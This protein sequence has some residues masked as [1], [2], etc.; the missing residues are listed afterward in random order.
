MR[1]AA[2]LRSVASVLFHRARMEGDMDDELRA[3]I[4]S[5]ADDLERS[6]LPRAEAQRR[7]RMEFGG[8]QKFKEECHEA[9]G[10]HFFDTLL[11]DM[12]YALRILRGSPGFSILVVLCLTL[13]IG[14]NAAV[15]SW[16]E[17]LLLRPFPAVAH[18]ER[19]VAITGTAPSEPRTD[20]SWPDFVDLQ[21]NCKLLDALITD[22]IMGASL[23]IGGRAD[24]ATG[25]IVSANYFDAL[26]VRPIL[27]RGFEPDEN[28]GRNAHPVA[29]ISYQ[30]WQNTFK[31]DPQIIGKMQRF[32][33]VEHT[34]I[35]VAPKGFYGTFVGWAIQFWVP[36]SMEQT[37]E[38]GPY[39]LDDRGARW[40]E[41]FA[42]LKPGVTRQQAQAE[43]SSV[44]ATLASTYPEVDRGHG[45]ILLPLWLTPFN[46]A[47]E[48]RP[49]L[50]IMLAVVIFV[51]LIACANVGNLL[52]VRFFARRHEMMVR[53]ALGAA[54]GRLVR[55]LLTEGLILAAFGAVGGLLVAHWCRYALV[56][57][58]P[59][60]GT[61]PYLPGEIDWRVLALSI[62]VCVLA[63]VLF[64]LVPAIEASRIDLAA[65]LKSE[66]GGLVTGQHRS[67]LRTSLVLVQVSLSFVLLV[68]AALLLQ[69]LQKMRNQSPGFSTK[70][71]LI[72]SIDLFGSGYDAP[73]ALNFQKQLV[74]RVEMLPGVQSAAFAGFVPLGLIPPT[75]APIVVDG[76]VPPLNEEPV[77]DYS[78][79]GPGYFA[80]TGVTLVSGRDF[81]PAD[82]DT[83]ALVAVVNE[84][85][86]ARFWHG[87]NPIGQR[88]QVGDHWVRVVGVA[89]VSKY[90]SVSEAPRP[91]FYMP[92]L[93]NPTGRVS[94]LN[95]RTSLSPQ[96]MALL[97]AREM[98]ALDSGLAHNAVI[99]MQEQLDRSTSAQK[100]AV[101]LL[102]VL[103]GLALV[104]ATVGLYSV[105]AYSVSQS[106]RE[107]GLRMALGAD[108]ANLLWHV[109]SRAFVLTIGGVVAGG[110]ACFALARFAAGLL[111]QV[112]PHDP[113]AFG[114]ALAIM[115]FAS[116]AGCFFPA[117]RASHTDPM[118]AL[119]Y[120]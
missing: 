74:A 1:L 97:L 120:E 37:F 110:I 14:A 50:S 2:R 11:K 77:V 44:A 66:M 23:S 42:M 106:R 9:L 51:L 82:N 28:T 116:M 15:F 48:L 17:G 53:L 26:G 38:G 109:M 32:N 68:G 76:Y 69:S 18:Q 46:K 99:S 60:T 105:V 112:S 34:I 24:R 29:V 73:R 114:S 90:Y 27:G 78:Q 62:G 80:T 98:T 103:G 71:V 75:S 7:A 57:F 117:W 113:V 108:S 31:G 35:G 36:V 59:R 43:I 79:V 118:V 47:G 12:R 33:K 84:P 58:F 55:Q 104:L 91:F 3:H 111:Y 100:A 86:A 56:F 45:V 87:K 107:F 119:R 39:A 20:M 6:G 63:T 19:M 85:M 4:Q 22:K 41:G 40:I 95:V 49:T 72:A 96:A 13:G 70:G 115:I 54:R 65:A 61:V 64:G 5:R 10:A 8:Y 52:L 67:W 94:V 89:K 16:I 92:L 88:L 21:R 81:T 83:A 102:G 30:M 93:Q 25:S 101:G